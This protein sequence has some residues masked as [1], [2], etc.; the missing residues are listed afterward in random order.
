MAIS[1]TSSTN[2]ISRI[3]ND[4]NNNS[5][6]NTQKPNATTGSLAGLSVS[7]ARPPQ[8][9]PVNTQNPG[10]RTQSNF[11]INNI[12]SAN[13]AVR[14][15]AARTA[16]VPDTAYDGKFVGA[17]GQTS[18]TAA[19]VQPVRPNNGT[20]PTGK[21]VFYVNGIQTDLA[22]QQASLQVIANRTGANVIGIHNSTEGFAKDVGQSALDKAN[23]GTNPPVDT[24][25][26][27]IYNAAK[28]GEQIN[29]LAHSQGGLI[30]SRAV[31]NATNRLREDGLSSKQARDLLSKSV[32]IQ[33]F[34]GA[35]LTYPPGPNYRHL[36]NT[37]DPVPELLG[38]GDLPDKNT[39]FFTDN[40]AGFNPL[41]IFDNH[42]F[43]N[44]YASRIRP[45]LFK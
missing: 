41:R 14:T 6:T 22:A 40:R 38:K 35:S 1:S 4:L 33:T 20:T 34:G 13:A 2:D 3:N 26:N 30:T 10:L 29:V 21:T 32:N 31:Q 36:V 12:A 17:N 39:V 9:S 11:S 43:D 19:G 44:V 5:L 8:D 42:S 24:L 27:A 37:A 28:K 23:L 16:S 7:A 45:D 25:A 18:N 15:S